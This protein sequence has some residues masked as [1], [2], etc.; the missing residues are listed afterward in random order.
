MNLN[1]N[2]EFEINVIIYYIKDFLLKIVLR[3][4]SIIALKP[5]IDTNT[6]TFVITLKPSI[7]IVIIYLT[8]YNVKPIIFLSRVI[9]K[10]ESRY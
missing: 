3:R 1:S 2:K 5:S 7:D 6:K 10:I 8:R 9:N 4:A